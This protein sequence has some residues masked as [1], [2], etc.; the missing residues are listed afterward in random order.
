[1]LGKRPGGQIHLMLPFSERPPIDLWDVSASLSPLVGGHRNVAFRTHGLTE[2]LVFKTSRR[3][4]EAIAWLGRVLPL[5]EQSGFIVPRPI[6][7]KTG[8]VIEHGWTCE[9]FLPGKPFRQADMNR[10]AS[11]LKLFQAATAAIGQRPGFLA[12]RDFVHHDSGGD[13]DLSRMP[14]DLSA[15]C[16]AAWRQIEQ[17][18]VCAVHGD[19]TAGNLL[20]TADNR[21]AVLDWDESRVDAA[22]FDT[23]QVDPNNAGTTIEM[24]VIA[25]EVACSWHIEPDYAGKLA[26]KFRKLMSGQT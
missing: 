9:P 4:S 12:A 14:P 15:L 13:L 24:A 2:N 16:R 20:L 1:V 11:P 3:T 17:Q 23:C 6:K 5:A 7:S 8:R 22:V 19:L 26:G 25:W 10:L 18:P 21:I